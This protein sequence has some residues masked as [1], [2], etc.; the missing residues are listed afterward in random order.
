M[1]NYKKILILDP[2]PI[3]R[4][5]LKEVIQT[6]ETRVDVSEA[7]TVGQAEDILRSQSPD[8]VFLDIAL[9]RDDGIRFIETIKGIAPQSRV[10]VLTN[11]DSTEHKE[12]ALRK[13]A[14]Y[15]L[16][17]EG[18]AGLRLLDVIHQTIRR[19]ELVGQPDA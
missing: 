13:G 14:D 18:T 12:A 6:N 7:Q 8:V 16:S 17:K 1:L 15:F 19:P 4:R 11:H 5:T 9:P 10:V 3:F 2:S